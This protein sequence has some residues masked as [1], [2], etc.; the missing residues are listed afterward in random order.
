[1]SSDTT[2]DVITIR[3]VRD[4]FG[5]LGN[6][7]PHPVSYHGAGGKFA[8]AEALFQALRFPRDS[9]LREEIRAARS[10]M[11]AKMIAKKNIGHMHVV[12]RSVQDLESMRFVLSLKVVAHVEVKNGLL[13]TGDRHIVEDCTARQTE[14]GL[15]WGAALR[16]CAWFGLNTLGILWMEVRAR[17]RSAMQ[18]DMVVPGQLQFEDVYGARGLVAPEPREVIDGNT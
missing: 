15:Y 2:K 4:P 14:S 12:P 3:R 11:A 10:P 17:L 13:S 5:Y 6:M 7:S 1:M 8:T 9:P 16:D 18:S